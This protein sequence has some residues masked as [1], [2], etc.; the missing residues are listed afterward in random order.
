MASAIDTERD[1][2]ELLA[3]AP[4]TTLCPLQNFAG[5]AAMTR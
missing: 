1:E 3:N 4:F 2:S 5:V